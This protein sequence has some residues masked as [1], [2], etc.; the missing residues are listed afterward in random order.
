MSWFKII[1]EGIV[2][3]PRW[4]STLTRIRQKLYLIGGYFFNPFYIIDHTVKV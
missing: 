1:T 4:G 2:P 3:A